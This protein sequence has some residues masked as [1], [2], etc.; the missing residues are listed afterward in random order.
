MAKILGKSRIGKN[1][2]LAE[3]V[4]IGHPGKEEKDLL[5]LGKEDD[6]DGAIIGDGC[7]LRD[8]GIIYSKAQLGNLV[9][10]GHHYLVREHTTIGEGSLVGTGVTIDDRCTIGSNVNIQ[11]GVYIPTAT[12]IEDDVFLG[13]RAVFTNDRDMGRSADW[14]EPV[15]VKRGA[16]VGANSVI[17]PGTTIGEDSVVGAGAVVTKNV[18][19]HA[20]VLG[21]PARKVGSVPDDQRLKRR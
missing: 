5:L 17:L 11:T 6:V 10:T 1:C 20:I 21:N 3:N 12:I 15:T 4:I 9:K 8:Y 7:I 13:P 2:Y 19:A 18:P 16:R 14:L